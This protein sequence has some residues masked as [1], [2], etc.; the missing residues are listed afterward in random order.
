[1]LYEPVT[2]NHDAS[3]EERAF[4]LRQIYCQ[5]LERQP[6]DF[7][8]L[9]LGDLEK[10]FLKGKIGIRHFLK[11]LAVSQLY[12]RTFYEQSSNV[13]FI[14]NSFKHFL[15]RAPHDEV[16]IRACDE[17]LVRQGVGAFVSELIDSEEYRKA[18]GCFTVPYWRQRRYESPSDYLETRFLSKEHAGDRGWGIPTLYWHELHLDCTGGV[19]RPAGYS[20]RRTRSY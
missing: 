13:K 20:S 15:G 6:Y 3:S 9:Q 11:N 16:E 14:E 1:M 8:R 19:C 12:L 17:R 18:F 5:V 4:I 7:E 10:A 2:T